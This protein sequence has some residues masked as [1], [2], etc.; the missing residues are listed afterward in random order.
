MG[1][2]QDGEIQIYAPHVNPG[3]TDAQAGGSILGAALEYDQVR[4]LLY[5]SDE[6]G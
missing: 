4:K 5:L 3:L 1:P 2:P 6:M